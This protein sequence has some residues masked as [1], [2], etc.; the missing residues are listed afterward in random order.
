M[1]SSELSLKVCY[2]FAQVVPCS[3]GLE[4]FDFG[5]VSDG[6]F[7][8]VTYAGFQCVIVLFLLVYVV[9]LLCE[10]LLTARKIL[11]E[12]FSLCLVL[13]A[14][15]TDSR[16]YQKDSPP[17]FRRDGRTQGAP[18]CAGGHCSAGDACPCTPG[19]GRD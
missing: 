2:T 6:G 4:G 16:R 14:V 1:T 9:S 3:L 15:N 18:A 10:R 5:M 13:R 19:A 11:L 8:Q 12:A 17:S 7:F